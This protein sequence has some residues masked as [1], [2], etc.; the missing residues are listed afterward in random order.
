MS[1][2]LPV[3][4]FRRCDRVVLIIDGEGWVKLRSNDFSD[5]SEHYQTRPSFAER[6]LEEQSTDSADETLPVLSA[7]LVDTIQRLMASDPAS[8]MTLT[9]V[10]ELDAMRRLRG[11]VGQ[12]AAL[13]EVLDEEMWLRSVLEN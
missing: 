6:V 5:L 11:M 10:A 3:S 12:S 8:R 4:V 9:E 7:T 2:F 1:F 13:V